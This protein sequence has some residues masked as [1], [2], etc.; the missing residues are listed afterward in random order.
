MTL[1]DRNIVPLNWS[2]VVESPKNEGNMGLLFTSNLYKARFHV[3]RSPSDVVVKEHSPPQK[4][5][6]QRLTFFI[7]GS[8]KPGKEGKYMAHGNI[9]K[10]S[11]LFVHFTH[12]AYICSQASFS[13]IP[14]SFSPN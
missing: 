8:W 10:F 1:C 6:F 9:H 2:K 5:E 13:T 12:T 7:R 14:P 3:V 11:F 4:K